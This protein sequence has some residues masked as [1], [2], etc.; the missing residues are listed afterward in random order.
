[1]Q[2]DPLRRK[3]RVQCDSQLPA[4]AHVE[5]EAFFVDPASYLTAQE[6]LGG[7]RHVL[8]AAERRRDLFAA[9]TKVVLVDD[10]Q[11]GSVLLGEISQR[12]SRNAGDSAFIANCVARPDIRC[13][14][15]Q[16]LRRLRPQWAI[17]VTGPFSV[18][19]AGGM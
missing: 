8:S 4:G 5:R 12:N 14:T 1:M 19:W 15:E 13:Q 18:P 2:G 11:R 16:F 9:R 17:G 3:V 6:C 7:I 10:E